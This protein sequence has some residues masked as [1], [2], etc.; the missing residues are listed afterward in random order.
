MLCNCRNYL[1]F[2]WWKVSSATAMPPLEM[3]PLYSW[4]GYYT[5]YYALETNVRRLH[6]ACSKRTIS[7]YHLHR[8]NQGNATKVNASYINVLWKGNLNQSSRSFNVGMDSSPFDQMPVRW[9]IILARPQSQ[10]FGLFCG[11][12]DHYKDPQ[13]SYLLPL[14]SMEIMISGIPRCYS[15]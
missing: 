11:W 5:S 3:S 10:V 15:Q 8:L 1:Q 12:Q 7:W 4:S 9:A 13:E 2:Q 14:R 6:W